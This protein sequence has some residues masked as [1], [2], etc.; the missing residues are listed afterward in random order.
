MQMVAE[1]EIDD[2]VS[3]DALDSFLASCPDYSGRSAISFASI[4]NKVYRRIVERLWLMEWRN[5]RRLAVLAE[6]RKLLSTHKRLIEEQSAVEERLVAGRTLSRKIVELLQPLVADPSRLSLRVG[7]DAVHALEEVHG[8]RDLDP[9]WDL[10]QNGIFLSQLER[11]ILL[12]QGYSL[13]PSD[14]LCPVYCDPDPRP[15]TRN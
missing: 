10:S 8:D 11:V 13:R 7:L 5:T 1:S 4:A 15:S 12:S 9:V 3:S 6:L 2:D 14:H